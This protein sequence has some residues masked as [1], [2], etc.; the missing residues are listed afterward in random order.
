MD[1]MMRC[2]PC[3]GTK[4]VAKLGGMIGDCDMCKGEGKI[5]LKDKPKAPAYEAA[6]IHGEILRQVAECVPTSVIEHENVDED[7]VCFSARGAYVDAPKPTKEPMKAQL[8]KVNKAKEAENQSE[9]KAQPAKV[10]GKRAIYKR[11]KS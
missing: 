7:R 4:K 3:K 11:K 5:L 2:P 8:K 1:E 6:P 10:N 9:P